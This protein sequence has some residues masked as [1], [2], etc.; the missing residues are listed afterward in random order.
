MLRRWQF[1]ICLLITSCAAG[2]LAP[3]P[4]SAVPTP[5]AATAAIPVTAEPSASAAG[6]SPTPALSLA[7]GAPLALNTGLPDEAAMPYRFVAPAGIVVPLGR[8]AKVQLTE[9]CGIVFWGILDPTSARIAA[10]GTLQPL[11][12]GAIEVFAEQ[13]GKRRYLEVASQ[14][15]ID[16]ALRFG[17]PAGWQLSNLVDHEEAVALSTQPTFGEFW[18]R[19]VT[20]VSN[21]SSDINARAS[22]SPKLAAP[23]P[24]IDFSRHGV[25]AISMLVHDDE[26]D[27]VITS[28][29]PDT[30]HVVLPD[31]TEGTASDQGRTVVA[32][33][34]TQA[35]GSR[36]VVEV[37]RHDRTRPVPG[38]ASGKPLSPTSTV[39]AGA[40]Y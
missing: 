16:P 22:M 17:P 39:S 28:L 34:E 37:I 36:S 7:A 18:R 5:P 9:G 6:V 8:T 29:D 4:S 13:N 19:H 24:Q 35:L 21:P 26:A 2:P 31:A 11:R 20:A 1:V 27:P 12:T 32:L 10:D 23:A 38:L 40:V 3:R 15:T 30:V 33:F 25:V 14:S